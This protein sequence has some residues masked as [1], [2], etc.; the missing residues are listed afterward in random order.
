[1]ET[2][3]IFGENP[4]LGLQAILISHALPAAL[5][6]IERKGTSI[7]KEWI[8][9]NTVGLAGRGVGLL[10]R[11]ADRNAQQMY[12][13]FVGCVLAVFMDQ[14]NPGKQHI[15]AYPEDDSYDVLILQSDPDSKPLHKAAN[16]PIYKDG[17]IFR[18]ELTDIIDFNTIVPTLSKKIDATRKDYTGRILIGVIQTNGQ[19]KLSDV[20]AEIEKISKKNFQTV[21]ILGSKTTFDG[22]W[23]FFGAE[24]LKRKDIFPFSV[25]IDW[26]RIRNEMKNALGLEWRPAL[27]HTI[28]NEPEGL[29]PRRV[30]RVEG[31]YPM[32]ID[33]SEFSTETQSRGVPEKGFTSWKRGGK[34]PI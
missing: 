2:Y 5:M 15:V 26:D 13:V 27:K 14:I 17:T 6:D 28:R 9:E 11:S 8:V 1:M 22:R 10:R 16:K 24:L 4:L 7:T 18:L 34:E 19:V 3:R 33:R 25:A 29:E 31:G 32:G 20:S 21:W 12:E 23:Q 30:V